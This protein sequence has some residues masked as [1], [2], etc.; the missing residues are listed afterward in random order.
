MRRLQNNYQKRKKEEK[1]KEEKKN[2]Q[3]RKHVH[4]S[5]RNIRPVDGIPKR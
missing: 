1:E 2:E 5:C 4:K 3:C